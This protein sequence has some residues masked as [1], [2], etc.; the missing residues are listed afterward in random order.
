MRHIA[1][2]KPGDGIPASDYSQ[3]IGKKAVRALP[4]DHKLDWKDLT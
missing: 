2:K 3:V 1:F 4:P